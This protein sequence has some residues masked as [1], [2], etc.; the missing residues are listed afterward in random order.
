MFQKRSRG[1][2]FIL[3][4]SLARLK[5]FDSAANG[6]PKAKAPPKRANHRATSCSGQRTSCGRRN[7]ELLAWYIACFLR[8]EPDPAASFQRHYTPRSR[9]VA[10]ILK[11]EADA[12][13]D[14]G[15]RRRTR[16]L[17]PTCLTGRERYIILKSLFADKRF[18]RLV[19]IDLG[20]A[21]LEAPVPGYFASPQ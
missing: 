8:S 5:A 11:L 19:E 2:I 14:M 4:K 3:H 15:R 18:K 12:G 7:A 17:L 10:F 9:A 13:E 20:N 16:P 6:A 21:V 1:A